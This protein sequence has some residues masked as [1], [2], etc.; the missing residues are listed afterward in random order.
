MKGVL[1]AGVAGDAGVGAVAHDESLTH[2]VRLDRRDRAEHPRVVAVDEPDG[3][4]RQQ[5]RVDLRRVVVLDEGVRPGSKP[6][7]RTSSRTWSRSSRQCS[8]GPSRP[9]CSTA[10]MARSNAA[11]TMAR[12]CV[13]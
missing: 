10:R 1:V 3:R 8:T 6:L 2:E 11:H 5:R 4:Q 13:K 9:C 12:E 7:V